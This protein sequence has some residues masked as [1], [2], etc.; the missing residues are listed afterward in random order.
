[1]ENIVFEVKKHRPQ[2]LQFTGGEPTF[3]INE[4]N[5]I[6][7]SHPDKNNFSVLITTNGWF[8]N[9]KKQI[10]DILSKFVR[11]TDLQ[12]SFDKFH[13]SKLKL[14][15]IRNLKDYCIE[16]KIEFNLSMCITTPL[17]LIEAKQIRNQLGI[18]IAFQKVNLSGRAKINN[19]S[20]CYPNFEKETLNKKCPGLGTM[21]Y[22]CGKG[23]SIC[24]SNLIFNHDKKEIYHSSISEHLNSDFFIAHE[25]NTLGELAQKKGINTSQLSPSHSSPCNLC[26]HIFTYDSS[27]N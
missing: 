13:G 22:I 20:F 15:N 19:L 2:R 12:L 17:E 6:I 5:N 1:M 11:I 18:K 24:C 27:T 7:K 26:E 16:S 14:S 8:S 3:Y 21:N 9:T 4:I 25:N 10:T 23:F